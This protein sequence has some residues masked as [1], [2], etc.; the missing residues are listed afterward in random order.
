MLLMAEKATALPDD[1]DF[2]RAHASLMTFT[3]SVNMTKTGSITMPA[4]KGKKGVIR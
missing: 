4:H 3:M 2:V 1:C